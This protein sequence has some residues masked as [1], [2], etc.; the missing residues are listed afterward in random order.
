MTGNSLNV[1]AYLN[2]LRILDSASAEQ[3]QRSRKLGIPA[4]KDFEFVFSVYFAPE[5]NSLSELK[6]LR[7]VLLSLVPPCIRWCCDVNICGVE[8]P[9]VQQ[10]L[11][12]V[13]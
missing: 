1:L 6:R 9:S 7:I 5:K 3:L 13:V 12:T 10:D 11:P 8:I 4:G 2:T